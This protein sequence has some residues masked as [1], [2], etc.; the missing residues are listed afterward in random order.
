M[1]H[2][3][4]TRQLALSGTSLVV[5]ML[6]AAGPAFAQT[7]ETPPAEEAEELSEVVVTNSIPPSR[8][9]QQGPPAKGFRSSA[10]CAG[11]L[12]PA[13]AVTDVTARRPGG[14]RATGRSPRLRA[15]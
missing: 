3:K 14:C 12:L 11:L 5:A 13:V 8:D 7:A 4:T 10:A 15:P 2:R 9:G 1:G 6:V